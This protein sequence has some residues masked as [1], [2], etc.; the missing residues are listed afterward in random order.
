M[1]IDFVNDLIACSNNWNSKNLVVSR[2][3]HY[4]RTLIQIIDGK[5]RY[6]YLNTLNMFNRERTF[7]LRYK[8]YHRRRKA[9]RVWSK[10]DWLIK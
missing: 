5:I 9:S 4:N 7:E 8:N 6:S 3:L 10:E 1:R 2:Y